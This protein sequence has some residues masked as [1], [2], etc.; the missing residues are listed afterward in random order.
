MFL[1]IKSEMVYI[2]EPYFCARIV[3]LKESALEHAC[4]K[5]AKK[6]VKTFLAFQPLNEF[7]QLI[8]SV[9]NLLINM[10][11]NFFQLA[12]YLFNNSYS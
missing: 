7:E 2:V 8:L 6:N 4:S 11:K 1:Y 10:F 5:N 12:I 9:G 3:F